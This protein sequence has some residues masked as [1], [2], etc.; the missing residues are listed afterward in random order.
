[1]TTLA[2]LLAEPV[3]AENAA[4]RKTEIVKCREEIAKFQEDINAE[5]TRMLQEQAQIAAERQRLDEETQYLSRRQA[6]S[7]LVLRRRGQSRLL[8]DLELTQLF[9]M[10]PAPTNLGAGVIPPREPL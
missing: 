1:M 6:E 8:A 10:P 3:T 4:A 2:T 9:T 7:E 5:N